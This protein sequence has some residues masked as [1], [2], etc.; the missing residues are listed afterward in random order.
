MIEF[1]V[2][3]EVKK[4]LGINY[5]FKRD[6]NNEIYVLCTMKDKVDDIVKS[7]E[8]FIGENVKIYASPGAPNSVLNKKKGK[9]II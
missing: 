3:M 8:E 5:D 7:Y 9:H 1:K 6:E 2:S 4:H